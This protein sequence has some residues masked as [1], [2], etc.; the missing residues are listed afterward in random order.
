MTTAGPA[1]FLSKGCPAAAPPEGV[2]AVFE[3]GA[4][5]REVENLRKS[6]LPIVLTELWVS[7]LL[8][9]AGLPAV[10]METF[11]GGELPP[12]MLVLRPRSMDCYL[13]V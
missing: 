6:P 9:V 12:N 7:V 13:H 5:D 1:S 10:W 2:E 8:L 3:V 4:I 11:V